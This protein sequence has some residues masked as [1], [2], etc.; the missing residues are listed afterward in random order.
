MRQVGM[1]LALKRAIDVTL[2]SAG[3]AVTSPLIMATA[4]VVR[5]SLGKPVLFRQ[6]RPGRRGELFEVLKFRTMRDAVDDAGKLRPDAERLTSV[7]RRLR[8]LSLDE[9]PQL[10]N[11]LKGDM[12]LVGP[13]PLL[14]QYLERYSA[15]QRRRHDVLPGITGWAQING[16][17]DLPWSE[18]LRLDVWYVDNWSLGLDA[19]ILG[20]TLLKV[21][22]RDGI[23]AAGQ[24]TTTEF[25]GTT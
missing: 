4:V 20:R 23:S 6:T 11:V 7:G 8:A 10:V 1:R 17:N 15:E 3:L 21:V 18:K 19:M 13:R 2:A 12:S 14:V 24:A 16:R 5:C 22:R 9:L 25:M